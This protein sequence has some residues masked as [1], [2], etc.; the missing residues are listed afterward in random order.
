LR[1][2]SRLDVVVEVKLGV[3]HERRE[4]QDV[5]LVTQSPPQDVEAAT[6]RGVSFA[7]EVSR[8][9]RQHCRQSAGVPFLQR[10][11]DEAGAQAH[12]PLAGRGLNPVANALLYRRSSVP[13]SRCGANELIAIPPHGTRWHCFIHVEGHGDLAVAML[14]FGA[15]RPV[16]SG[17][18]RLE[19]AKRAR[20]FQWVRKGGI[21]QW[22][23]QRL[24]SGAS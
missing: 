20:P 21:G 3:V 14:V 8:L 15:L 24:P 9:I 4:P 1:P 5:A 7:I 2:P 12:G 6:V 22:S 18:L 23:C 13:R 10:A 19:I 16:R 11:R 17:D